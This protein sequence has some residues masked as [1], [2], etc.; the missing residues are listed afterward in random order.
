[1]L[2]SQLS[3]AAS[4]GVS[5]V[6]GSTRTQD[7]LRLTYTPREP[8]TFGVDWA[9]EMGVGGRTRVRFEAADAVASVS[10]SHTASDH[11]APGETSVSGRAN[12]NRSL[13]IETS[14]ITE[15]DTAVTDTKLWWQPVS[16]I[17]LAGTYFAGIGTPYAEA[18][19][20]ELKW[21]PLLPIEFSG[22]G[23]RR[24]PPEGGEPIDS[25]VMRVTSRPVRPL[26]LRAE[27]ADR[28][29]DKMGLPEE[30]RRRAAGADVT[31]G[32]LVLGGTYSES[33]PISGAAERRK[34]ELQSS[35]FF[36]P[37]TSCHLLYAEEGLFEDSLTGYR[38]YGIGFLSSR[39]SFHISLEGRMKDYYDHGWLQRDRR[40]YEAKASL[41]MRF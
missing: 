34:L 27:Y 36:G 2:D 18:A 16:R 21:L 6:D 28:P 33:S 5:R 15:G 3:F 38:S 4:R 14:A 24:E 32:A 41:G 29:E 13:R 8:I 12:V 25:L 1:M 30:V 37:S 39:G 26:A 40:E 7:Q 35:V 20:V 17:G 22:M 10:A 23:R 31:V 19:G 9:G 11:G